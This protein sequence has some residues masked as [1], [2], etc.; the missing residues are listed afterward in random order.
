[1]K[2]AASMQAKVRPGFDARKGR[3]LVAVEP[4]RRG[5]LIEAAPVVVFSSDDA[6][7]IDRTPLFDYYFRWQGDI[8]AGGSGAIAFGLVSLCNHAP[9]PNATVRQNCGDNTLDLYAAADITAGEE[10]TIC[11]CSLWFEPV[12]P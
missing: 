11:Y 1:M 9:E 12:L 2:L 3:C 6:R 4:I 7:L 8:K 5:A 10:I